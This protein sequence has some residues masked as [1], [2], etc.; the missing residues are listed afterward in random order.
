MLQV[1]KRHQNEAIVPVS[2]A[3]WS[4]TCG[5]WFMQRHLAALAP[6]FFFGVAEAVQKVWGN[7]D[8][9]M[10]PGGLCSVGSRV[11]HDGGVRL[12]P[13]CCHGFAGIV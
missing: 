9:G 2:D 7:Q 1:I 4:G 12:M 8:G 5:S 3:R 11:S 6:S 13:P 10:A